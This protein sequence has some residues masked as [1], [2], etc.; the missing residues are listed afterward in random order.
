MLQ[1][2]VFFFF[3]NT[4]FRLISIIL[5]LEI[6][7]ILKNYRLFLFLGVKMKIKIKFSTKKRMD[8]FFQWDRKLYDKLFKKAH[9]VQPNDEEIYNGMLGL[10]S[11][12]FLF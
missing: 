8:F 5:L 11:T 1:G 10:G 4:A 6:C 12:F 7:V 9:R 3:D 2:C